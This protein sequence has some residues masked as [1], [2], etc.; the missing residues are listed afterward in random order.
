MQLGEALKR[1]GAQVVKEK[2]E[3]K[4]ATLFVRVDIE[5]GAKWVDAVTNL[6]LSAQGKA[7]TIDVSKYFYASGGQVKYLWRVV[8]DGDVA[9]GLALWAAC[10]M[11]AHMNHVP[12]ITSFPL[13]GRI[14]YPFDP[15]K[16][17][18]KGGHEMDQAPTILN[19]AIG[20]G[21][22]GGVV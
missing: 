9:D 17:L 1:V 21:V 19:T 20:A 5:Q 10:S 7:F 11:Q 4:R 16:G 6:L 13:I 12:E 14:K 3:D 15:A 2:V 22:A 18:L 8:I